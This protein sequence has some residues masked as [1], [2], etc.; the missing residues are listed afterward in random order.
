MKILQIN[1]L[2]KPAYIYGGPTMSVS[3]LSE[4]LAKNGYNIEVFTTT[5]NG[6][7]E[8]PVIKNTI[9]QVNGVGVWYFQ[10]IS[11]DHSHF[12]PLLL[13]ALL[14]RA[15]S[16]D[17][18]H[19]H[20]WWNLVSVL[21]CLIAICRDIPIVLS[22]RGT[23]SHY[24]FN[25]NGKFIKKLFHALAGRFLLNHCHIHCTSKREQLVVARLI[26]PL[27]VFNIY[28]LVQFGNQSQTPFRKE[29]QL[30]LLYLSRI[31][32]KKGIELLLNAL[33]ESHIPWQLSIA[34]D[35]NQAYINQ[36]KALS[37]QYEIEDHIQWLGFK[38][39]DKF[40]LMAQHEVLILPSYDENFGNVIIES[41]SV[42][43]A[44]LVSNKVGLAS[45][46]QK[47]NLGWVCN[48]NSRSVKDNL[49]NIYQHPEILHSI[50]KFAPEIIAND[51]NK[52][53]LIRQYFNMYQQIKQ[54]NGKKHD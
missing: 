41:L 34:G 47:N 38:E 45:Y 1:A 17:L 5:A 12:A 42:G 15:R 28:N 29:A 35:G 54:K 8:L 24:T 16:F 33:S 39:Q 36:L 44:V 14:K 7:T 10:R 32:P 48:T 46:I 51:F 52:D 23:L 31:A 20:T 50:R 30:K 21:S 40:E 18:I 13:L 11:K 27:N 25:H 53:L 2:Y 37:R 43:T 3:A 22:P 19:I 6:K 49:N 26:K 4:Q 9:Q